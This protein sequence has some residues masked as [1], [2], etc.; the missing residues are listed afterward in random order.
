MPGDKARLGVEEQ[1]D[2]RP[3]G[4]LQQLIK[5]WL[6]AYISHGGAHRAELHPLQKVIHLLLSKPGI[7]QVLPPINLECRCVHASTFGR[8]QRRLESA[9]GWI[10]EAGPPKPDQTLG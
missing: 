4:R 8:C 5:V 6:V 9:W 2:D 1:D 10:C 3:P 7:L